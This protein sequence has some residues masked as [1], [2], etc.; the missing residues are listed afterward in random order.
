MSATSRTRLPVPVPQANGADGACAEVEHPARLW[1]C[2]RRQVPSPSRQGHRCHRPPRYAPRHVLSRGPPRQNLEPR[3]P[4][5][6]AKR[7]P[8][9][10]HDLSADALQPGGLQGVSQELAR[11]NGAAIAMG[12][13][14]ALPSWTRAS[15]NDVFW[16]WSWGAGTLEHWGRRR[17]HRFTRQVISD[18]VLTYY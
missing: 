3:R 17:R 6:A 4:G 8:R 14:R 9:V 18:A 16:A 2:P 7:W 12:A 1:L 11:V 13:S 5:R 10:R 15:R